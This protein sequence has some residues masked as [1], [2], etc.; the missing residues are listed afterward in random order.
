ADPRSA[1][2]IKPILRGRDIKRYKAD[3][4]DLW[5]IATFPALKLNIDDYPAVKAHLM[6]YMP[7]IKQTGESYIDQNGMKQKTRKETGHEWFET[8]DPISYY[9]DFEKEKV[10]WGN[11]ALSSQFAL[12]EK[13][14]FVNAPS[15]ML[16]PAN[17]YILSVLN[18]K[19]GDY[20]IRSLG[21]TRNGGYFEY[22]PMFVEKLPIPIAP[23]EQQILFERVCERILTLKQ[24]NL[25]TQ[26]LESQ[27]DLMV[28]KLY[29]LSYAEAKLIDPDL[30]SVFA[31]FGL[32]AQDF[33]RM[34]M[35][36]LAKMELK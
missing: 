12:A 25:E 5:L 4:A 23:K 34:T 6:T 26:D 2:I 24:N 22:K 36:Q 21:V 27:I 15:P 32:S 33:E 11:L 18:S 35:E 9:Q 20:Y 10:V 14:S 13:G 29:E 19:L 31:S 7:R 3:F 17:R 1:E 28:Y 30:D 8:Q 16:T